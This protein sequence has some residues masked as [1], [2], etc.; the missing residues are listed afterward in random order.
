MNATVLNG[1]RV[2]AGSLVAAGALVPENAVI[3]PGRL[4]AGVPGKVR[5]EL[6]A[7][8]LDHVRTNAETYVELARR[9]AT[10]VGPRSGPGQEGSPEQVGSA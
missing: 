1:A 2:G 9:H 3:P 10:A 6:A 7:A 8:E 5:R 4:V